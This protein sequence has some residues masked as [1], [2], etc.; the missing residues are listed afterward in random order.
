MYTIDYSKAR[1]ETYNTKFSIVMF[2]KWRE[3]Q[4][5]GR[6]EEGESTED[7]WKFADNVLVLDWM[8]RS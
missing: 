1:K 4:V 5:D 8:V 3:R 7:E 6:R 2:V